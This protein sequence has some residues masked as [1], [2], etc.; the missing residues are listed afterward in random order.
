MNHWAARYGYKNSAKEILEHAKYD[1]GNGR[2]ACVNLTNHDTIEFRAFRG[3]LNS[4]PSLPP[5]SLWIASAGWL[6]LC[7]RVRSRI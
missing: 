7:P 2:Y 6:L 5:C 3:T 1:S 4:T